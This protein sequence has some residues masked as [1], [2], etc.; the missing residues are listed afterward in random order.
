MSFDSTAVY[1]AAVDK[2]SATGVFDRVNGHESPKAPSQGV[3]CSFWVERYFPIPA[4]SGP[5]P[6]MRSTRP[7]WPRPTG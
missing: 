7:S 6:R 1:K 3:I 2:A 5:N 4:R